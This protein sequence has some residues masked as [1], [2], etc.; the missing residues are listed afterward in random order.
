MVHIT[1]KIDRSEPDPSSP[2][3]SFTRWIGMIEV[4]VDGRHA[5][6]AIMRVFTGGGVAFSQWE[7]TLPVIRWVGDQPQPEIARPVFDAI[8]D[9]GPAMGAID[10]TIE[11]L[12]PSQD[13]PTYRR[14]QSTALAR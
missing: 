13:L 11:V 2:L 14:L 4:S 7:A 9:R 8:R 1:G 5:T 12:P 6:G 10:C 3:D